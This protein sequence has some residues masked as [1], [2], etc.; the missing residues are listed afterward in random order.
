MVY[1]TTNQITFAIR[2]SLQV[3]SVTTVVWRPA[4]R[5]VS[6]RWRCDC[7]KVYMRTVCYP[8][9]CGEPVLGWMLGKSSDTSA[10]AQ[11]VFQ[12]FE[13]TGDVLLHLGLKMVKLTRQKGPVGPL[14]TA[15][16]SSSKWSAALALAESKL[17]QLGHVT[18]EVDA[19]DI[20]I[21]NPSVRIFEAVHEDRCSK[22]HDRWSFSNM[23]SK[24]Q[25]LRPGD[26]N[27]SSLNTSKCI[28]TPYHPPRC[29]KCRKKDSFQSF[30]LWIWRMYWFLCDNWESAT[31]VASAGTS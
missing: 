30:H 6:G 21:L 17:M 27:L 15:L 11:V 10:N 16:S 13:V 18:G 9:R 8:A 19:W 3:S 2:F 25:Y 26:P 4:R 22:E 28:F 12:V 14:R 5:A 1:I 24:D 7:G 20:L 31:K 29:I 23:G